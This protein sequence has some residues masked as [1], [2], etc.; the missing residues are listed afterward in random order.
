MNC[1]YT[2]LTFKQLYDKLC[3]GIGIQSCFMLI[4]IIITGFVHEGSDICITVATCHL[5]ASSFY[6]NGELITWSHS[7]SNITYNHLSESYEFCFTRFSK[8]TILTEV[9]H[10]NVP[11]VGQCFICSRDLG[12]INFVSQADLHLIRPSLTQG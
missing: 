11:D 2:Y 1:T 7:T 5:E 4:V 6:I 12:I 8:S 3:F 9:C 10:T